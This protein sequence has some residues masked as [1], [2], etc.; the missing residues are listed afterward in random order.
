MAAIKNIR[1]EP[2]DSNFLFDHN[3]NSSRILMS[4]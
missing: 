1:G 2:S 3:Q 4:V